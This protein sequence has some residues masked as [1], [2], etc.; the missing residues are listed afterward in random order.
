MKPKLS[1][2][3]LL[4]LMMMLASPALAT[5]ES[6]GSGVFALVG[7]ITSI[8]EVNRTVTIEVKRG[9]TLAT[10]LIGELLTLATTDNTRFLLSGGIPITF[11]YLDLDQDISARGFLNDDDWET[12]RIT[13]GAALIC[14]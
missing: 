4:V 5:N 10:V 1:L 8:D 14:E 12:E 3:L 11:D 6:P 2:L 7:T 9:N 13:V